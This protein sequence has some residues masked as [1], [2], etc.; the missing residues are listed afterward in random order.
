MRKIGNREIYAGVLLFSSSLLLITLVIF[1]FISDIS[2]NTSLSVNDIFKRFFGLLL[3]ILCIKGGI[4]LL[5]RKN[6]GWVISLSLLCFFAGVMIYGFIAGY[7]TGVEIATASII[8]FLL[9][10]GIVFLLSARS[11]Q[12]FEV[13]QKNMVPVMLLTASLALLYIYIQ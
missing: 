3:V 12:K 11:R 6:S 13:S 8:E 7:F 10:L 4:Q 1:S 5:M 2:L 9:I